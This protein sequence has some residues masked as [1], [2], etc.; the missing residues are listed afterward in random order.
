MTK[1]ISDNESHQ[2]LKNRSPLKLFLLVF[3]LSI[4][5]WVVGA[6]VQIHLLP[7]IPISALMVAAPATA[8]LI[9]VYRENKSAGVKA[10]LQ[11]SFDFNRVK[12]KIW[13]GPI[14]LLMPCVLVLSYIVMYLM[15]VQLLKPQLEVTRTLFLF[16]LFFIAALGEELGWSGYAIDLLQDRF[17]ALWAALILGLVWVVWHLIPLLQ[18]PQSLPFIAWWSLGTLSYRVI[19]TWL[20]NNTGKSVFVAAFFHTMMN[21]VFQLFP[22]K[23]SYLFDPRVTGLILAAVAIVVVI[24]WG[25]RT[26]VRTQS[27]G[28][29]DLQEA[30]SSADEAGR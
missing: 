14:I 18:V 20:Y 15:G 23:G 9:L 17:D 19:I 22:V 5:F 13:W 10:L 25:P 12:S 11:R 2:I 30:V 1:L 28:N 27:A 21:L 24:V 29:A 16:A 4:P 3:A 7:S 8:A 6:F 26:L